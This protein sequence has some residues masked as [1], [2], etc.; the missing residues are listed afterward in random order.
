M[1]RACRWQW[2]AR[3]EAVGLKA[4]A[5]V[6]G[7]VTGLREAVGWKLDTAPTYEQSDNVRNTDI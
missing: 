6:M 4:V 7:A 1:K 2:H 5:S 3:M